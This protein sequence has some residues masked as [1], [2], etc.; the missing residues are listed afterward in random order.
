MRVQECMTTE[1]FRCRP[2]TPMEEA[3]RLM[4]EHDCGVLPVVD[5][6]EHVIGMVTDRDLCM[7]A[8][9]RGTSLHDARVESAMSRTV[10][11]CRPTDTLD[12]AIRA[13]ADHGVRR[14]PVLDERGKLVGILSMNDLFRRVVA[15]QDARARGNLSVRLVEALASICEP[16]S[17]KNGELESIPSARARPALASAAPR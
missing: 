17:A 1:V 10:H 2:D 3:A 8:Y 11:G 5:A 16:H 4:W 13:L 7:G 15:L 14:V 6:D 12:E 9:T